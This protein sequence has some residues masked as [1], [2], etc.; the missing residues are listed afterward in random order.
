MNRKAAARMMATILGKV[1]FAR[2]SRDLKDGYFT[3]LT[4]MNERKT[5]MTGRTYRHRPMANSLSCHQSKKSVRVATVPAA[6]GMGK[7]R[8]SLPELLPAAAK[9]LNRASRNAPQIK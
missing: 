4:I 8:K 2:Q 1:R 9:Q 6:A 3:S 7:P 5:R